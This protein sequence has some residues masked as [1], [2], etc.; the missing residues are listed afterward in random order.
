M[1]HRSPVFGVGARQFAQHHFLTAHNSFVLTLAELRIVGQFLFVSILVLSIKTLIVGVRKLSTVPGTA[2]AQVWGMALLAAM[3]GIAFQ[4]NT[5][6]FAYHSVPWIFFGLVSVIPAVRHH[7]PE[8]EDPADGAGSPD[9]HQ[10]VPDLRLDRAPA[11]PQDE[12]ARC[13]HF[14]LAGFLAA[15]FAAG[16]LAAGAEFFAAGAGFFATGAGFALALGAGSVS[17]PRLGDG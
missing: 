3:A 12:G 13:S 10:L 1:W 15:G 14:F 9:H 16:F 7:L 4:I 2:A 8:L 6:S 11:L 5:L 17:G